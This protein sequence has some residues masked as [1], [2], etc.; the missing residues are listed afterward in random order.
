[1]D[2]NY[3]IAHVGSTTIYRVE[4]NTK[5]MYTICFPVPLS[6]Y[7]VYNFINYSSQCVHSHANA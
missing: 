7:Q 4:Y 1:M 6:Q 2:K 3:K 5:Y